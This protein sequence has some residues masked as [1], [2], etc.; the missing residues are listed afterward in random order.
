MNRASSNLL[1]ISLRSENIRSEPVYGVCLDQ[2]GVIGASSISFEGLLIMLQ[3]RYTSSP[4]YLL[5][6]EVA[7][8]TSHTSG[9]RALGNWQF[10]QFLTQAN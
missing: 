5:I 3:S 9:Y 10:C 2:C 8:T 6:L 1:Q 4:T 7:R